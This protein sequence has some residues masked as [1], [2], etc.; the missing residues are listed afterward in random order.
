MFRASL[1]IF[2]LGFSPAE[3][4]WSLDNP[5]E[6]HG[7]VEAM[8]DLLQGRLVTAARNAIYSLEMKSGKRTVLIRPEP[9]VGMI[10]VLGEFSETKILVQFSFRNVI[11]TYDLSSGELT[12]LVEGQEAMYAPAYGKLVYHRYEEGRAA[13][14]VVNIDEPDAPAEV[15]AD[16]VQSIAPGMWSTQIPVPISDAEFLFRRGELGIWLY[17]FETG[18]GRPLA[19]LKRCSLID[20]FWITGRGQ[21]LCADRKLWSIWRPYAYLLTDLQG[22]VSREIDFGEARPVAYKAGMDG[23]LVQ[24]KQIHRKFGWFVF[25]NHP[26]EFYDFSSGMLTEV[27]S[28]SRVLGRTVWTNR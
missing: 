14:V 21:L 16:N 17:S 27:F 19:G 23:I 6:G 24:R 8:R 26:I 5:A 20:A 4:A 1:I 25:V 10:E 28:D 11:A 3:P 2:V 7:S 13:L 22:S 9:H 15:I 18:E 12:I